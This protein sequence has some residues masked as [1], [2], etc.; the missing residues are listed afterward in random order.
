MTAEA[1]GKQGHD[2]EQA[3]QAGRG[4][5]DGLVGPLPLGLDAEV[6]ADLPEGD[7]QPPAL[8][9]PAEDLQPPG[10]WP[11]RP[12]P[13]RGCVF[14]VQSS[15]VVLAPGPLRSGDRRPAPT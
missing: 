10:M 14:P 4:A 13:S 3:E 7:F 1:V 9:E 11:P 6:V 5:G 2:G 15:T 12:L 8:R